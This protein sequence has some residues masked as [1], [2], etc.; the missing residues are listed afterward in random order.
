[1][2][3]ACLI[4]TLILERNIKSTGSKERWLSAHVL[5][6]QCHLNL[7]MKYIRKYLT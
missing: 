3:K 7:E 2:E 5:L 1:M 6:V 4:V